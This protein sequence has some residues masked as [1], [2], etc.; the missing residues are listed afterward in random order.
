RGF[1]IDLKLV[2]A[3]FVKLLNRWLT[4]GLLLALVFLCASFVPAVFRSPFELQL[5]GFRVSPFDGLGLLLPPPALVPQIPPRLLSLAR[6]PP[7]PR[8]LSFLRS[9][10]GAG[11]VAGDLV[12]PLR[13]VP[14]S[15][16]SGFLLSFLVGGGDVPPGFPRRATRVV[17]LAAVV[18]AVVGLL[19]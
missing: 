1:W 18:V 3:T 16:A 10:V 17:A 2:V 4:L 14:Y 12:A 8:L 13:P 5:A 19:E 6:T 15:A 11:P 9:P 7:S